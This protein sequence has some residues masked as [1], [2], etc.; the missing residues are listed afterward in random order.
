MCARQVLLDTTTQEVVDEF[1]RYVRPVEHPALTAFCT[2]LTGIEQDQVDGAD[3]L[4]HVLAEFEAWLAGHGL[5]AAGDGDGDGAPGSAHTFAVA[6]DGPWDM[7]HFLS[8][9]CARK[10]LGGWHAARP[11]LQCWVNVRWWHAEFYRRPRAGLVGMLKQHRLE[12]EG[13]PHS[14]IDDTRNIARLAACL[15][16][17][18]CPL[19][20]NDGLDDHLAVSVRRRPTKTKA[21]TRARATRQQRAARHGATV[22]LVARQTRDPS[23]VATAAPTPA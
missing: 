4:P 13:R 2:Q 19:G 21:T 5:Q 14:G 12:F 9:E 11:Y 3:P 10:D 16:A 8:R 23:A 15:L 20:I 1:H 17:D 22:D 7:N 6:T 18:G